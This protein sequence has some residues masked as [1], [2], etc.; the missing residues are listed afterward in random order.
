MAIAAAGLADLD[1]ESAR[2]KRQ[3][4]RA[5]AAYINASATAKDSLRGY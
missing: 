1:G 2:L 5:P 3:Y 4:D